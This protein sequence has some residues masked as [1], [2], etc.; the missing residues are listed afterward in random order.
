MKGK[1]PPY[2]NNS[3]ETLQLWER[4]NFPYK[5]IMNETST[6][7]EENITEFTQAF[8]VEGKDCFLPGKGGNGGVAGVGGHS[9][10]ILIF[11][12]EKRPNFNITQAQG[13]LKN[14]IQLYL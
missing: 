10:E 11:G 8:L 1:D 9:G 13:K 3:V 12:L 6:S 4:N 2:T 7:E 5:I 14:N